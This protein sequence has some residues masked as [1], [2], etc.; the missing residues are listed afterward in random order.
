L[1]KWTGGL[2]HDTCR[3]SLLKFSPKINVMLALRSLVVTTLTT[4]FNNKTQNF[5]HTVC[6]R[7]VLFSQQTTEC[8][9]NVSTL[10]SLWGTNWIFILMYSFHSLSYDWS[11][12]SSKASSQ[13]NAI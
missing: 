4:R 13:Q 10:C 8:L 5:A 3:L 9:S 11:I 1:Q 7:S 2:C 6:W 12:V